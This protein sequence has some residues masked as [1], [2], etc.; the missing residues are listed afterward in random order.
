M[1]KNTIDDVIA[2]MR[3]KDAEQRITYAR[4]AALEEAAKC[5]PNT[6]L[7]PLLTGPDAIIK[8][9]IDAVQVER[10]LSAITKRIRALA[11]EGGKGKT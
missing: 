7:D 3:E 8:S 5:V 9:E 2:G 11:V 6:W 1:S 10:L 4:R